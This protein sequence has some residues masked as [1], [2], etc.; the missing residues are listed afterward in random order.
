MLGDIGDDMNLFRKIEMQKILESHIFLGLTADVT[1]RRTYRLQVGG[2]S[3][4]E[5]LSD[6]VAFPALI[7]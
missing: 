7:M 6:S 1:D 4:A 5:Y 2:K 3:D